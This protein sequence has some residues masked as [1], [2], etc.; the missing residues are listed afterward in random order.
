MKE[1]VLKTSVAKYAAPKWT[2]TNVSGWTPI[3]SR[4]IVAPYEPESI[5]QGGIELP[6]DVV[7]RNAMAAEAG[8]LVAM[9]PDAFS[10]YEFKPKPGDHV[11]MERFAGQVMPGYDNKPYRLM[12]DS[13]IGAVLTEETK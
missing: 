5:T 7:A 6:P 9:G 13:C 2:G 1:K 10:N 3:G 11:Y 12:E 4:V 8:V